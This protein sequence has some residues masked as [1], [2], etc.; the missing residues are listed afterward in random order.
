MVTLAD[1]AGD[2]AFAITTEPLTQGARVWVRGVVSRR[3]AMPVI[4]IRRVVAS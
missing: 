2:S 4:D 1:G 3:T